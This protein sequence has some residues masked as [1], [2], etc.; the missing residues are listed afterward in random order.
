MKLV[1]WLCF[2]FLALFLNPLI[3]WVESIN[4]TSLLLLHLFS[5][6]NYLFANL[7][8][9]CFQSQNLILLYPPYEAWYLLVNSCFNKIYH[10]K[11]ILVL[12]C[13]DELHLIFLLFLL[14]LDRV[15]V[16][17][18]KRL[19]PKFNLQYLSLH[20]ERVLLIFFLM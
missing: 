14:G 15:V 2:S 13:L 20:F 1:Q 8:L 9:H 11:E 12:R 18:L 16:Q 7:M 5:S 3:Y 17:H 6:V 4:D 19:Y 10:F